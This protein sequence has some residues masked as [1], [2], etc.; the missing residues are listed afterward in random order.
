MRMDLRGIEPYTRQAALLPERIQGF[1]I[2]WEVGHRGLVHVGE[3]QQCTE[4][5]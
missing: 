3:S 5:S 1:G 4:R 2:K